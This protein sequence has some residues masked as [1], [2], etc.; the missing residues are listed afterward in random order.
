MI[1]AHRFFKLSIH[2]QSYKKYYKCA[3]RDKEKMMESME[4]NWGKPY[5]EIPRERQI[6]EEDRCW[7]P[8]WAFNGIVGY[9]DFGMDMGVR[10]TGNV[11]LMR[12]Y[13]PKDRWENRYRKNDSKAKKDEI[14][15]F[16]ETGPLYMDLQDNLSFVEGVKC[17]L[18]EAEDVIKAMCKTKKYKWVLD[19]LPF[20]LECID[21]VRVVAEV[22]SRSAGTTQ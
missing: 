18:T 9:V 22:K 8:P 12:R 19:K 3:E 14:L 11:F 17:I 4:S 2:R 1:L 15:Y 10:L 21:F 20:S 13:F 5:D 16:C 7:W 6:D